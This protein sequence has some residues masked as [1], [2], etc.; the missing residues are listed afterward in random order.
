ME[1]WDLL[2]RVNWAS[3]VRIHGW[4]EVH[5]SFSISLSITYQVE[6]RKRDGKSVPI[7]IT[8]VVISPYTMSYTYPVL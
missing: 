3:Q 6:H 5:L 4:Q 2:G 1:V 7:I 8:G